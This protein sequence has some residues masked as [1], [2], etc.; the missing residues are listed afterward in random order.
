MSNKVNVGL[1]GCGYWGKNLLRNL[2]ENECVEV[3][4]LCDFN[5]K[6]LI[7]IA[8]KNRLYGK[9]VLS[10]DYRS[11]K[12][13]DVDAFV[14]ATPAVT[15]FDVA[16]H[17]LSMGKHCLIEKPLAMNVSEAL[18]LNAI[19]DSYCDKQ[20]IG[21]NKPISIK[22]MV[23]HTFLYNSA[24]HKAKEI[25]S[26]ENYF[27]KTIY[28]YFQRLNLGQVKQDI[29]VAWNLLPHDISIAN[30]LFDSI[31]EKI[32]AT[33]LKH[34][35]QFDTV[36]V[37]LYYPKNILVHMHASWIDP[38]KVRKFVVV[39][40]KKMLICDDTDNEYPIKIYDKGI[41]KD[42]LEGDENR[43][44]NVKLHSGD[45]FCPK[46][47]IKEPLKEEINHFINCIL[48]NKEPLTNGI[49]GLETVEILEKINSILNEV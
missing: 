12:H 44:Y 29:N 17:L 31:P 21:D 5:E 7:E 24:V 19:V 18:E 22:L 39:G 14:V 2:L 42:Y 25:I 49:R 47:A 9:V 45:I 33:G 46:V 26:D 6:S 41:E 13:S 20:Y 37:T 34:T 40:T 35:E 16:F 36:F 3:S 4:L 15:H 30:Y 43:V 32:N 11:I 48:N 10:T 8:K 1:I 28:A 27:G 23:G 38:S